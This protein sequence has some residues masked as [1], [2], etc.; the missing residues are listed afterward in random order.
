MCVR[1]HVHVH[2]REIKFSL[3]APNL[4]PRYFLIFSHDILTVNN[5]FSLYVGKNWPCLLRILFL[6][7]PLQ[8]TNL[9]LL[10]NVAI[11]LRKKVLNSDSDPNIQTRAMNI[12]LVLF[13]ARQA[14]N[15]DS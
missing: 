8:T 7:F 12:L 11:S 10:P 4:N 2:A 1:S 9:Q 6:Y 14:A 5:L 15:L 13:S 3:A